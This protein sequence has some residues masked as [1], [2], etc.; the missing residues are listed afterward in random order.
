MNTMQIQLK[1]LQ[2]TKNWVYC[3]INSKGIE[4]RIVTNCCTH[5]IPWSSL[6]STSLYLHFTLL[7]CIL[8]D[9]HHYFSHYFTTFISFCELYWLS[10]SRFSVKLVLTSAERGCREVGITDPHRLILGYLD[11]IRNYFF[12]VAPQ[13]YSRGLMDPIPDPLLLRKSDSAGNRTE[14]LGGSRHLLGIY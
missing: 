14:D 5:I 3:T 11:R 9:F 8:C 4:I 7:H 1:I 10:D 12:Q 13:L 6:H 2:L